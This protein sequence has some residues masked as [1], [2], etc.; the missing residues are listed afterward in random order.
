[1][2]ESPETSES[3]IARVKDPRDAQAWTEFAAIYRPVVIRLAQRR[4]LQD[5]DA[6]DVAQKVLLAVAQA[7]GRWEPRPN[8]PFRAWL[9]KVAR[10]AIL[11]ALTRRP[12]DAGTGLSAVAEQLNQ[13]AQEDAQTTAELV[14]E[15]RRELFRYA[16]E[17]IRDEFAPTTWDMFWKTEVN[18]KSVA[19]VA[20]ELG[21][22]PGAVYVARCRVM[23]RLRQ[24]V[25][26]VQ[27]E[28]S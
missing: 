15:T 13:V 26:E 22:T 28:V 19:E 1:M 17:Q 12:P 25:Q 18:G 16:A 6:Q 11:N 2:D 5:A 27:G 24:R 4:G 7:I 14:L 8:Q 9:T 21:R 10:N 23:Q 20:E 3:L